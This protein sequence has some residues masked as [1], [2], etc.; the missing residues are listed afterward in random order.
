MKKLIFIIFIFSGSVTSIAQ[1]IHWSQANENSMYQNPANTGD[2]S[3]DYRLT[4]STKDQWRNV[5]KP[6]QT[7]AFTFDAI[8]KYNR[9][10]GYGGILLHDVTG[11]GIFRTIELKISPAYTIFQDIQNKSK[12]RIGLELDFKYNQMNY[13]NYMFDNQFDGYIY[14]GLLP[15]NEKNT[16]QQKSSLSFGFGVVYTKALS[17]IC[18][19]ICGISAYNLNQPD[20]GFYGIKVARLRRYHNFI[21]LSYKLSRNVNLLPTVNFQNQGTYT[22]LIFGTRC[23]FYSSLIPSKNQFISGLYFRNKDALFFQF[24]LK[25]NKLITSL[26]Y[27]INTSK[28]AKAS[29]GRGGLEI[30]IQYIWSRKKEKNIM[31]KKCL[32]YL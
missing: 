19:L 29:N 17:D 22:E 2:M 28:L 25:T 10:L 1:D 18:T 16:T 27:D 6:Y 12:I 15:S 8:N 14:S 21:Q 9:K 4:M 30:N 23:E 20:Q 13:S 26:N 31:H 3:G 32:D 11:D 24:G 7:Q 5:T